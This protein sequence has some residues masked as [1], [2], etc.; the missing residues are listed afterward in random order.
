VAGV[1]PARAGVAARRNE[2]DEPTEPLPVILPRGTGVPRPVAEEARPRGPFEPARQH[3]PAADTGAV[4]AV[5]ATPTAA[6]NAAPSNAVAGNAVARQDAVRLDAVGLDA[7]GQDASRDK[8][9]GG[10]TV[11]QDA[12]DQQAAQPAGRS[13]SGS[14]LPPLP[15]EPLRNEPPPVNARLES[16]K[17]LYFTAAAIGEEALDKHFDVV[18]R[19]QRE[20]IQEYFDKTPKPGAEA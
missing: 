4:A 19:R 11:G 14:H 5:A 9:A 1:G 3:R 6:S 2:D 15:E 10:D 12:V 8:A 17:D 20:L 18:S 13:P 7:V 16:L